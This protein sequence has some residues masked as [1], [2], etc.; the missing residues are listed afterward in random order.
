VRIVFMPFVFA[1]VSFAEI[2]DYKIA[3]YIDPISEVY[4]SWAICAIF[5]LYVS[6]HVI[7]IVWI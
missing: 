1:I 5:L 6:L 4:E 3:V 2:K 7:R